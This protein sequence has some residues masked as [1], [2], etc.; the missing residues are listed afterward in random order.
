MLKVANRPQLHPAAEAMHTAEIKIQSATVASQTTQPL[1]MTKE[2]RKPTRKRVIEALQ[3]R[4]R[5]VTHEDWAA[6]K[7][8]VG[9]HIGAKMTRAEAAEMRQDADNELTRWAYTTENVKPR[10]N[11]GELIPLPEPANPSRRSYKREMVEEAPDVLAHQASSDAMDLACKADVLPAALEMANSIKARNRTEKLLAHQAVTMHTLGMNLVARANNEIE[12]ADR[13][14]LSGNVQ[15]RQVAN[16]EAAR[17]TNA[18]ARAFSAFND[19]MLTLQKLR[20]GG[21]QIVQVQ[22]VTVKDGGQ[23][24]VGQNVKGGRNPGGSKRRGVK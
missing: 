23:A 11:G 14:A 24:V 21:K 7:A 1:P 10:G 5:A 19:A 15:W 8:E 9:D 20:T 13:H 17:A 18:A 16:V 12:R 2:D 6:H 4:Q 22:H 3:K